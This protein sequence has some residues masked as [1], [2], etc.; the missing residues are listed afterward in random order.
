M[1]CATDEPPHGPEMEDPT[2]TTVRLS[3]RFD[4]ALQ[5]AVVVHAGQCRKGTAIPYIS[6]L[7]LV[8]GLAL[9]FGADEDEAIAALLHDA[10]EDAGGAGRLQDIRARFGPTVADIVEGCSDTEVTPKPPWRERK[11]A[12]IDH[13]K[14]ASHG[15]RLVSA[16]DKLANVRSITQ[17]YRI[18][19]E[20]VWSRF[21]G[22]REGTLWYCRALA[23]TFKDGGP[24]ALAETLGAAVDEL[25]RLVN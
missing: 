17:D 14:G 5:Y 8:V 10:V 2:L 19:G 12:Y 23:E 24:E 22:G 18:H 15:I 3:G 21:N 20:T 9:E 7:L 4:K 16:A 1:V 13:L 6:H 11:E 25:E